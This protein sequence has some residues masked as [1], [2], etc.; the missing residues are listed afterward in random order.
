MPSIEQEWAEIQRTH[1]V[2][3]IV[4][5]VKAY[6]RPRSRGRPSRRNLDSILNE[7][8]RALVHSGSYAQI[9]ARLGLSPR[10]L[11]NLIHY[12]RSL[13]N[14]KVRRFRKPTEK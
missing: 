6:K 11:G 1:S 4:A 7:A 3:E 9:A 8:A 2:A 14:Q 10:Q 5:A 13:F 12:H